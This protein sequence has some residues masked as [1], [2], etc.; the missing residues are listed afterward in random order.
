MSLA[1]NQEKIKIMTLQNALDHFKNL[2]SKTTKKSEIKI[3]RKFIQI[4]TSLENSDLLDAEIQSIEQQLDVL[5]LNANTTNNKK[6]LKQFQKYLKDTFSL[7]PKG[8]YTN[9]G[10]GLGSSF[11]IVFGIVVL[12]N[13]ERTL[14]ISFGIALGMLIGLVIGRNLDSQAKDAGKMI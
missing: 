4:L 9:L 6:A 12:S 11:G 13:F 3:Y 5:H 8:Y 1:T 14:G 2:E 10:I 7:T